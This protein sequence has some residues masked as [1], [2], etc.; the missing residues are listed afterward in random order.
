MLINYFSD[1]FRVGA[2]NGKGKWIMMR[3]VFDFS[4]YFVS[5]FF[6]MGSE[7]CLKSESHSMKFFFISELFKMFS[8]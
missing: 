4:I 3:K 2:D 7:K 8:F 1:F 6:S 5:I